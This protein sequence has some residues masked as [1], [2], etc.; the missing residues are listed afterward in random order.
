[1]LRVILCVNWNSY[2]SDSVAI[3]IDVLD[4]LQCVV[5][6]LSVSVVPCVSPRPRQCSCSS[7]R[8]SLANWVAS[9]SKDLL[10]ARNYN[11]GNSSNKSNA[12]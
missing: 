5:K 6:C 11:H 7:S 9:F 2:A 8:T 3:T 1:M 10:T 12:I 4:C